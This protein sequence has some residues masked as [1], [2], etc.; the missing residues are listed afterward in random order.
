MLNFLLSIL[1]SAVSLSFFLGWARQRA[2]GQLDKMQDAVFNTP[3][4]EAP[5][6]PDVVLGGV[7][8]TVIHFVFGQKVLGLRGWQTFL[9]FGLGIVAGVAIYKQRK[10]NSS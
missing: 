6:P 9:S 10:G 5:V 4:V 3:G 8:L 1:F 2:E 7:G